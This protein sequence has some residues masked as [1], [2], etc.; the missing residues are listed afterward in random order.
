MANISVRFFPHSRTHPHSRNLSSVARRAKEEGGNPGFYFIHLPQ[1]AGKT[2]IPNRKKHYML[3][4][5]QILL[6]APISRWESE[7]EETGVHLKKL[8]P[9]DGSY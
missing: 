5:F 7:E 2:Y 8:P 9:G 6:V 4:L 3:K 1:V